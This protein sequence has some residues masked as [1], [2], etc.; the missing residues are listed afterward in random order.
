MITY[1]ILG[2]VPYCN[3][4]I[5]YPKTLFCLLRPLFYPSVWDFPGFQQGFSS[6][7]PSG[8]SL[9]S[10]SFESA[11]Y[12]TRGDL[13]LLLLLLPYYYDDSNSD[14]YYRSFTRLELSAQTA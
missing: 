9:E 11:A 5:I 1:T 7:G 6:Q 4:S 12:C 10:V 8:G 2:G 3:Y 13:V 14:Y